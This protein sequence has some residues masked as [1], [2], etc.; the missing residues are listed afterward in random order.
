MFSVAAVSITLAFHPSARFQAWQ[1]GMPVAQQLAVVAAFALICALAAFAGTVIA[2]RKSVRAPASLR[3]IDLSGGKPVWVGIA[4]GVGEELLFRGALQPL[5]GLW[6]SSA[7]FTLAHIRTA[8]LADSLVKK[9]FYLANVFVVSL[10]LGLL[11]Q[12]V[13]LLAAILVHA[14][15]DIAAL[16]SLRVTQSRAHSSVQA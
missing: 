5:L 9:A 1:V 3:Q 11:Y 10:G 2:A 6:S 14:V 16:Y 12:H 7:L 4:A 13:G 8:A 15:I